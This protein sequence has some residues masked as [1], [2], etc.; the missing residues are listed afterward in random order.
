[1]YSPSVV[2]LSIAGAHRFYE[3]LTN[4]LGLIGYW[5]SSYAAI[6][7]VEYVFFRK[8][9]PENYNTQIWDVAAKLPTG[10]AALSAGILSFGLVIP[11]MDQQWFVGP[12]ASFT[13]DIGFEVALDRKSVV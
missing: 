4:F 7:T 3:T 13:G 5:A 9:D 6:L 10:I 1:M 8:N 12:I 2:P 11:S